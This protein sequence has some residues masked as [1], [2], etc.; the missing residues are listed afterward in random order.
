MSFY[1]STIQKPVI[2]HSAIK[3][4]VALW[5]FVVATALLLQ[6]CAGLA[7]TQVSE[8]PVLR[9]VESYR[10]ARPALNRV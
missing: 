7:W 8:K 4:S 3:K 1:I 5:F 10:I 6:N 9:Q 2:G